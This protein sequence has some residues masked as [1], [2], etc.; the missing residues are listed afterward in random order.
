MYPTQ[1]IAKHARLEQALHGIVHARKHGVA[2]KREDDGVGVQRTNT[3]ERGVLQI[4]IENGIKE[5]NGS[6][7]PHQHAHQSKN[8]GG[9]KERFYDFV[10]VTEFFEFHRHRF[11]ARILFRVKSRIAPKRET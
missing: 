7:E 9:D 11:F 8:D 4:K 6:R 2:H 1:R 10:V 3:T 5:L